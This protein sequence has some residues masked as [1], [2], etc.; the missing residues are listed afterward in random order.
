M[1]AALLLVLKLILTQSVF[2]SFFQMT[3]ASK[4][5][6][7]FQK[8]SFTDLMNTAKPLCDPDFDYVENFMTKDEDPFVRNKTIQR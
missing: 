4:E 5:V 7:D 8:L 1:P 3:D 6:P 2:S